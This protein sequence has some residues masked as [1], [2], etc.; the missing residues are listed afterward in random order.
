MCN[1]ELALSVIT[2]K[3]MAGPRSDC[4]GGIF[5]SL[6]KGKVRQELPTLPAIQTAQLEFIQGVGLYSSRVRCSLFIVG[7]L[8][9]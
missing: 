6:A 3:G 7:R 5:A 8:L 4:F 1:V 2:H 9:C